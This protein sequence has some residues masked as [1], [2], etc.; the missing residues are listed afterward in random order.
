MNEAGS[1]DHA[2]RGVR[3]Q[4]EGL[5]LRGPRGWVYRNID[6][7]APPGALVVVEGPPGSGRTCLLLTLAGR[8]RPT[9]GTARIGGHPLPKRAGA[10]RRIAALGPVPGV[11]DPEPALTVHELMRERLL[12]GRHR[13]RRVAGALRL[14]GLEPDRLPLSERTPAHRLDALDA[15]RLGTAAALLARPGLLCVDSVLDPLPPADRATALGVLQA[16]RAEGTTVVVARSD[17]AEWRGTADLLV[18]LAPA[19]P[20]TP[21]TPSAQEATGARA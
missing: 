2:A 11:N 20:T 12:P 9:T 7:D 13:A 15:F 18:R 4:T 16:A 17:A 10:V 1:D 14:V 5:G 21:T 3:V 19:T 6:I 8:M